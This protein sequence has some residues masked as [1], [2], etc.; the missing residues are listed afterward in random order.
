[1][2]VVGS[3]LYVLCK[4]A[5]GRRTSKQVMEV[6]KHSARALVAIPL[7]SVPNVLCSIGVNSLYIHPSS[8]S[9]YHSV[10][11]R[12]RRC[13]LRRFP[14]VQHHHLNTAGNEYCAAEHEAHNPL[15]WAGLGSSQQLHR[16]E[17]NRSYDLSNATRL[18]GM[19]QAVGSARRETCRV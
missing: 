15:D 19:I 8:L 5:R 12:G 7:S 9:M 1:M 14:F 11:G 13:Y 16:R 6:G 10:L 4:N 3:I 18:D 2:G 17:S